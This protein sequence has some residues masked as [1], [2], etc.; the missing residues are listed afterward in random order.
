MA[1]KRK[2]RNEEILTREPDL[3]EEGHGF[4]ERVGAYAFFTVGEAMEHFLEWSPFCDPKDWNRFVLA[5]KGVGDA[6]HE[7]ARAAEHMMIPVLADPIIREEGLDLL[8]S[9][10]GL[11]TGSDHLM[12]ILD[13]N[14]QGYWCCP[15][16]VDCG[17]AD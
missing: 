5:G 9:I 2:K 16:H 4:S 3:P 10:W 8:R 6:V 7:M 13:K 15:Q 14:G 11:E 17:N 12:T 1:K